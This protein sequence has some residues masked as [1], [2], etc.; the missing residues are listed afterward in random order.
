MKLTF[1]GTGSA[2]VTKCFNTCFVLS[3]GDQ[4]FL[5]DGGGG[6]MLMSR[7]N[8]AEIPWNQIKTI[9]VTHKHIDHILGIVWLIRFICHNMHLGKYEGEATIYAHDEVIELLTD[10]SMKLLQPK[11]TRFIGDRMHLVAV[12]D[13]DVKEILGHPTTFF[14]IRSTKAKQFGF[15]MALPEGRKLTCCGDEPF[16]EYNR[17]IVENSTWL[18]HEAFCLDSQADIFKP[19]EK[20]HCTV[21][22]VCQ[23]AESLN[24]QQ[25]F[26]YHSEEK[27]MPHK[28]ELYH[29]EGEP[30]YHGILHVPV[31]LDTY[32]LY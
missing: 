22:D 2:M 18:M 9:F 11:Q 12:E 24:A 13:G 29:R 10:M 30:Y 26:L 23:L 20:N 14:D 21:K 1:L 32:E 16:K 8:E 31:D 15:S 3:E 4:H 25:L 6:N 7:L 19:H 28:K 27:T 5:V 17:P